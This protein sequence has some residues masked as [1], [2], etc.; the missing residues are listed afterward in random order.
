MVKCACV[1]SQSELGKY[2]EWIIMNNNVYLFV[3]VIV[4]LTII[5]QVVCV[6]YIQ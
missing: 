3:P 5:P 4:Y 6:G 2:F 1:F